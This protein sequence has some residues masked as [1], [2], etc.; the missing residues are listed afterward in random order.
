MAR[1]KVQL[2]D[3]AKGVTVLVEGRV[4]GQPTRRVF[5]REVSP[6]DVPETVEKAM[7]E[8][9]GKLGIA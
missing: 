1:Y 8:L 7:L 2:I 5:Y 3:D 6:E 4:V 9:Q